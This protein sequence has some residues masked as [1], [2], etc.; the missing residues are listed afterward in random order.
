MLRTLCLALALAGFLSCFPQ[1]IHASGGDPLTA[2]S[3]DG[4]LRVLGPHSETWFR[5]EYRGNGSPIRIELTDSRDSDIS[6]AIY[7][8]GQIAEWLT[9]KRVQAI[10]QIARAG[11]EPNHN[12]IWVGKFRNGGTYYVAVRNPMSIDISYRLLASGPSVSFPH[13]TTLANSD[14]PSNPPKPIRQALPPPPQNTALV[15][16]PIASSLSTLSPDIARVLAA[17]NGGKVILKHSIRLVPGAVYPNVSFQIAASRVQLLGDATHPPTIIPPA[18]AYGIIAFDVEAPVVRAVNI[19]TTTQPRDQWKWYAEITNGIV[20]DHKY[21]GVLFVNTRYGTI[22]NVVIV[23]ADGTTDGASH[24]AGIVGITLINNTGT[25]VARNKLN[26]NIF[27][28]ILAGGSANVLLD[29]IITDNI[30]QGLVPGTGDLCNGCDSAG[31]AITY[32]P[33][34]SSSHNNFIGLPGHGNRIGGGNAVFMICKQK[35]IGG[36]GGNN[37]FF[38]ENNLWAEWNAFE[39]VATV[40]NVFVRNVINFSK[41]TVGYWLTGSFF[42]VDS[43]FTDGLLGADG[44]VQVQLTD[45]RAGNDLSGTMRVIENPPAPNLAELPAAVREYLR[46]LPPHSPYEEIP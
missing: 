18:G 42:T 32:G 37:N 29:N 5:F 25:L 41:N 27:G 3:P 34:G 43:R 4:D 36:G 8:P 20:D 17:R 22:R 1:G 10:G 40:G 30:R 38:I 12:L 2:I 44:K 39:A 14:S 28:L 13:V 31:I 23:A 26:G 6:F 11:G 7:T 24:S 35:Q 15:E 33:D 45:R 16:D 9:G 21:G 19:A 46:Q